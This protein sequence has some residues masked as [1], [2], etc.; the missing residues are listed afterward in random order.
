ME[1]QRQQNDEF[2]VLVSNLT[3]YVRRDDLRALFRQFGY[4]KR[5]YVPTDRTTG[6]QRGFAFVSFARKEDAEA[7]VEALDGYGF[8]NLFLRVRMAKI[9]VQKEVTPAP[10]AVKNAEV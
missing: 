7:A 4:V 2:S 6:R 3:D 5:L 9:R 8:D 10:A 1:K